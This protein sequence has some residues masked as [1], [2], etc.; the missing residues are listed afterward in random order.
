MNEPSWLHLNRALVDTGVFIH[1]HRGDAL[2]RFFFRHSATEIY[3]SKVTRKELLHP[4]VSNA[5][6]QKIINLLATIR[7]IN[8]DEK[9]AAA[10]TELLR[11]YAYLKDHLADTLIAAT[12][13]AKNLPLITTNVRH[14][15]PIREIEVFTFHPDLQE[16]E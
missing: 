14:F 4:F 10:Y 1:W 16:V 5:E 9:I 12:A 6:R 2:A 8:P 15:A 13:L 11:E 7:V 3:Y